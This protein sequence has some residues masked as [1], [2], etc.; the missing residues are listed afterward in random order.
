MN[1]D[2]YLDLISQEKYTEATEYKSSCIPDVLYKYFWLDDNKD[3]NALR[4]STL[5][6]GEIYLSTLDQFNDPFEGKAFVFE[7]DAAAPW[8]FRKTDYQEFVN[9]INSHARICCFANPEE[10]H[11][12][13]PMWAYYANNH[14]GF[15]VEYQ[16]NARQKKFLYPVSYDPKRVAGNAFLGNLI[17]GIIDMVKAG[18]DSSQMSGDLSVYN[19]LAYLSLTCKHFSWKH[20]K[21]VRALVPTQCGNYFPAIPSKI[22]VGMNCSLEHEQVLIN[23]ARNFPGCQLFKMKEVTDDCDFFLRE[24][25]LV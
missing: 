16:M 14:Q 13:M 11:Q 2:N 15:C 24:D 5:E 6:R 4:L 18:K 20:E 8:G 9:H 23:I 3:K 12:N 25:R 22:Y 17:M 10:K 21:E 1:Y 19:H 7:D